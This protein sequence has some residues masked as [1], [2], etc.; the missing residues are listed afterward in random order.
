MPRE[1]R[2]P[3][4]I[5][6]IDHLVEHLIL[7]VLL[8][9]IPL[10]I[11]LSETH[12][13][14]LPQLFRSI[15]V[16]GTSPAASFL[17]IAVIIA[18]A[19]GV[20]VMRLLNGQQLKWTGG[21]F[22]AGLLLA[23]GVLSTVRAGQKH[24][25]SVGVLDFL[26]LLLYCF[27]LRQLLT[28]RNL[29]RIALTIVL[30]SGGMIFAKCAYQRWIELP[31]TVK[32]YEDHKTELL[33]NAEAAQSIPARQDDP[34]SIDD[35][36]SG[37]LYDY[38]ARLKSGSAT[39]YFSHPNVLA[40]TLILIIFVAIAVA[41]CR[42]MTRPAWSLIA[43][44]VI[45]G[46]CLLALLAA[47]SKGAI[48]A[49]M[50]AG[51]LLITARILS[52]IFAAAPR[53]ALLIAWVIA[54][55]GAAGLIATLHHRPQG[56]GLSMFY[57]SMYWQG[58]WRMARDQGPLGVGAD[59]FGRYFMRYKSVECPEDVDD[60]HS[61]LVKVV[62]E[63]G[64]LGG[65]GLIALLGGLSWRIVA[66]L[67]RRERVIPIEE[68][69]PSPSMLHSIVINLAICLGCFV[70][71]WA[72]HDCDLDFVVLML[73]VGMIPFAFFFIASAMEDKRDTAFAG[74]DLS[75][76]VAPLL[77]G[78]TGFLLHTSVDLGMF[79]AGPATLFFAIVAVV[80][81]LSEPPS[82][83]QKLRA[84]RRGAAT[85][86]GAIGG[87]ATIMV[88]VVLAVP[89][90]RAAERL[91]IARVAKAPDPADLEGSLKMTAYRAA[92]AAYPLDGTAL[93]EMIEL[94]SGYI[95]TEMDVDRLMERIKRL[96][97]IDPSNTSLGQIEAAVCFRRYLMTHRRDD[98][99]QAVDC[100]HAFVASAPKSP[101]RWIALADLLEQAWRSTGDIL[102]REE[103]ASAVE[104]ALNIDYRRLYVSAA[105]RF[106]DSLKAQ[107]QS[108]M[109][110]LR[111]PG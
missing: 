24:L 3:A 92:V 91:H 12:T 38:E 68:P 61:W 58:A 70:V 98:L 37:L 77:A 97:R 14:E 82:S 83:R 48:A 89:A 110:M 27:T 57:R 22:G 87:A 20:V 74:A 17:I 21:E 75:R 8:S 35:R 1:R 31:A 50:I 16:P 66:D 46:A 9:L 103:A 107:L 29:V 53:R 63:W 72:L 62:V 10:R 95:R 65:A 81:A 30:A 49:A 11:V 88:L 59:N 13:F 51:G 41:W 76:A 44:L 23:A 26:A 80:L 86:V 109:D 94:R 43:P 54:G 52:R 108:R 105:N 6:S 36:R 73:A 102:Y 42:R 19:T 93:Q 111:K 101:Y 32:Y 2:G 7:L 96:R 69:V 100:Q 5:I 55:L 60:P 71:P 40:S 33:S 67:T 79:I 15:D 78:L 56:L 18:C 104:T 34:L 39:G 85:R 45:A 25:A 28:D 4:A 47:Q 84:R 99:D 106:S 64:L 90:A